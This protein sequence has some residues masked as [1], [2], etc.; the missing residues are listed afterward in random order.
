MRRWLLPAA[1]L[2][3]LATTAGSAFAISPA[4][5]AKSAEGAPPPDAEEEEPH[6]LVGKPAPAFT[7]D[8]LDG[9]K[10]DLAAHKGK[11]VVVL[12]FWATWC[13][14]CVQ[15]LPILTDVTREY[16]DKGVVFY[17]VNQRE[18]AEVIGEFLKK[19][20]LDVSVALDSQGKIGNL[21]GVEGIPQTVI[22]DKNGTVQ[23]VHVGF[24]P[25][26]RQRLPRELDAVLAGKNFAKPK[27]L[28]QATLKGLESAWNVA[29]KFGGITTSSGK[30][31]A[32]APK[33]SGQI[34]DATGKV[35]AEFTAE[36]AKGMLRAAHLSAKD[37]EDFISFDSW[38]A[39]VQAF[40]SKGTLLWKYS[41]GEGVDDVYV[42]DLDGDG[43]DEVIVGYN[44]GSGVHVLSHSG[45]VLWTY[46]K[47]S[48]VWHVCAGDL[49]GSGAASIFTTS[50]Q[51]NVHVFDSTG[52]KSAD[53]K[54]DLYANMVRF[55]PGSKGQPGKILIAGSGDDG[56]EVVAA[57]DPTGKELWHLTAADGK[58]HVDAAVVAPDRPWLAVSLRGGRVLVIDTEKGEIVAESV[59]EAPRGEVA[60]LEGEKGPTLVVTGKD[61]LHAYHVAIAP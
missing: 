44:G 57:L 55:A 41:G 43:L 34:V 28:S 39:E 14:P 19:K 38:G 33:G 7:L 50:A 26:L 53:V 5:S 17:A 31:I 4:A 8:T 2:A 11:D 16:R 18:E 9:G 40:D 36:S 59:G 42:A 37:A 30:I 20:K 54:S 48:N 22:I 13:G 6:E 56:S 21:Y 32:L 46:Q 24:G 49:Q 23:I 15:A 3:I 35:A 58:G 61:A 12:D 47:L 10:V 60:W 51:G 1:I 45:K 29:G 52:K 25:D 27:M